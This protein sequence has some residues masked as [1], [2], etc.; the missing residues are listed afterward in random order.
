MQ[1]VIN[2]V[3]TYDGTGMP[4]SVCVES[5]REQLA[6][7]NTACSGERNYRGINIACS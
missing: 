6:Q 5:I 7:H 3:G 2:I 4:W 1:V